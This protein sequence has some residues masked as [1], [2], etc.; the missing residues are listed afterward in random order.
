MIFCAPPA[1]TPASFINSVFEAS[2]MLTF[3]SLSSTFTLTGLALSSPSATPPLRHHSA[4]A[5]TPI[6]RFTMLI[7][8]DRDEMSCWGDC[9]PEYASGQCGQSGTGAEVSEC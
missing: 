7:L 8:L 6:Q 2:L 3:T 4:T 9:T 1:P 5:R